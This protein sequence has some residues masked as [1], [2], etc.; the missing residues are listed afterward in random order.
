[1]PPLVITIN[2]HG[3][4]RAGQS[5]CKAWG[6]EGLTDRKRDRGGINS[7]ALALV[8]NAS[9]GLFGVQIVWGLQGVATSRVFQSLGAEMAD[10]PLLWIAA[11]VTGLLVHPVV[12]WLS[13]RTRGRFGRRRPYIALGA[14]M[15]AA[16]MVLMGC[17]DS[18]STAV[19]ALWLLTLS[20]NVAMQP[21]RALVADLVG[22]E[23]LN[24]SLIH[25]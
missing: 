12:G 1:M 9:A 16:A 10:L 18:L 24:L 6:G 7:K 23:D 4:T 22:K 2:L 25:I 19:L 8:A 13:D 17:A 15:T 20:V 21:M 3:A 5:A 14:L 11:P